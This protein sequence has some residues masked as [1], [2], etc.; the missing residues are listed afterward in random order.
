M[1]KKLILFSFFIIYTFNNI[2][3]PGIDGDLSI[4]F[5]E[6]VGLITNPT[7]KFDY[8]KIRNKFR[9]STNC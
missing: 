4:L 5:G 9:I 2:I 7:G 8:K 1:I 6:R 3:K